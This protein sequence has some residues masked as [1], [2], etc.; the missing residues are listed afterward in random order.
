M[1]AA[2][3]AST[4]GPAA[5]AECLA[6]RTDSSPSRAPPPSRSSRGVGLQ[7]KCRRQPSAR[8][9]A[10]SSSWTAL[11]PGN[12]R[13]AR[14]YQYCALSRSPSSVWTMPCSHAASVD[15]S[16]CTISCAAC[17][18]PR[19]SSSSASASVVF[20]APRR[21]LL[22][23]PDVL[24]PAAVVDDLVRDEILHVRVVREAVEAPA[25]RRPRRVFLQL[26]LDLRDQCHSLGR[27]QLLRLLVDQPH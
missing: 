27:V 26:A 24:Q 15:D 14:R 16:F 1:A 3:P 4:S 20:M 17:Q 8:R 2:P 13:S 18:S 6:R 7:G 22:V 12:G 25:H 10:P 23:H 9:A 11:A 21:A 5:P 19:S